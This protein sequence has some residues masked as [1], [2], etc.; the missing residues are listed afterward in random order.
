MKGI[1]EAIVEGENR[2]KAARAIAQTLG[3]AYAQAAKFS[4]TLVKLFHKQKREILQNLENNKYLKREK[5]STASNFDF[6]FWQ[7]EFAKAG[8]PHIA[9]VVF[10]AGAAFSSSIGETFV[11]SAPRVQSF[12]GTRSDSYATIV[13]KTTKKHIDEI[14]KKGI[15]E[16]WTIVE[17]QKAIT[18]YYAANAQFRASTVARTEMV[19]G[20]NFGKVEGMRQS[21]R[22]E[23]HTWA[24]QRDAHV[25]DNHADLDGITVKVGEPFPVKGNYTGDPTYPSDYNE[26]CSTFAA[27]IKPKKK[28]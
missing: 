9:E 11:D 15:V 23:K 18:K 27:K 22:V 4:P 17:A 14:L 24:T 26:R 28:K 6:K 20:A 19:G 3:I 8:E 13:N 12:I 5:W 16:N 10:Q 2:V 7:E 21:G 25:R 1:N